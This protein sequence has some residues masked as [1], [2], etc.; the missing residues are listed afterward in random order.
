[1]Q[2]H[3]SLRPTLSGEIPPKAKN[4][5]SSQW[6]GLNADLAH[7]SS[8]VAIAQGQPLKALY[9]SR[10]AVKLMHREWTNLRIP[11]RE[12]RTN[13][14]LMPAKTKADDLVKSMSYLTIHDSAPPPY[15][16]TR[17]QIRTRRK[18]WCIVPRLFESLQQLSNLYAHVG[19][20][21]EAHYY[22]E[23]TQKVVSNVSSVSYQGRFHAQVGQYMSRSNDGDAA[24]IH[25]EKAELAFQSYQLDRSYVDYQ[26]FLAEK[27]TL[28]VEFD[29]AESAFSSADST[30]DHIMD[31]LL[32]YGKSESSEISAI[33]TRM[34][35]VTTTDSYTHPRI[36]R[37][38]SKGK[39]SGP[40]NSCTKGPDKAPSTTMTLLRD[41]RAHV[42]RQR[43][44]TSLRAGAL[45]KA[46]ELL[47]AATGTIADPN[48]RI[49][50]MLLEGQLCLHRGLEAMASDLNFCVLPESSISCPSLKLPH[51]HNAEMTQQ[52]LEKKETVRRTKK[53]L[54]RTVMKATKA[55]VSSIQS[56]FFDNL[57]QAQESLSKIC[58]IATK[59]ASTTNIHTLVDVLSRTRMML[60]SFNSSALKASTQPVGIV[61]VKGKVLVEILLRISAANH[62]CE[63]IGRTLASVR[64][65]VTLQIE[66]QLS[67][68]FGS[69]DWPTFRDQKN[70]CSDNELDFSSDYSNFRTEYIDIIPIDWTVVSLSL[71]ESNH[72][73]SLSRLCSGHNPFVISIP[74]NRHNSRDPDEETF[75]FDEG[76]AELQDIIKLANYSTHNTPATS[77]K[78]AKTE[79]WEARAALDARLKDFLVN[80]ESIWFGGFRGIFSPDV[81]DKDLLLRF[82]QTLHNILDRH[83]PSR[84]KQTKSDKAGRFTLDVQLTELFVRLGKPD[85]ADMDDEL[86]DLL[87]FV[88]DVLQFHGEHNAYDEIDF[89]SIMV[90]TLDALRQYHAAAE[91]TARTSDSQH[92][93]LVLDK[94]LHAFPWESL[95]CMKSHSTSR[96]PSLEFLRH[97][98]LQQQAQSCSPE[99]RFLVNP[100][101]GAYVL[102]PSGDLTTTQSKFEESLAALADW[103]SIVKRE[104]TEEELKTALQDKDLFLYF[105]HGSGGQYI[106]PRTIKRLEKCAVALLMGCSSGTM[107]EAGQYESYGTPLNYMHAGCPAVLATLWDVT[108]KDIDRF[109]QSVLEKWGLFE[110]PQPVEDV[111]RGA[112]PVKKNRGSPVKRC[113]KR[114][115][116]KEVVERRE[117]EKIGLDQAVAQSRDECIMKYLNGAAPVIYGIPVFL[118]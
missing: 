53:P 79:W 58:M 27:Y 13:G 54:M 56:G 99:A 98:I 105:G 114:G 85:A 78:G 107:T 18:M 96:V 51:D 5:E 61:Y 77:R 88:V 68:P 70:P 81:H 47:E 64:E 44:L 101:S 20:L 12:E 57:Q 116:G 50:Q 36:N 108:D 11:Q 76:K 72:E 40:V 115:N 110:T 30:L 65:R 82:Q 2:V 35:G 89:D 66:Q 43:A 26:L 62:I 15:S 3:K 32:S 49:L 118:S 17:Y 37:G 8:T 93:I 14:V 22:M 23:Q 38:T 24:A 80:V 83:L 33:D 19:L 113:A 100:S 29:S 59:T 9:F 92:I 42:L 4:G 95:P 16:E 46:E 67:S 60:S 21:A 41:E 111:G 1:M 106:R 6:A 74:L 39:A 71:S 87:Y 48:Q 28:D 109:S 10:L 34:A 73:I 94:A 86:T 63:E 31:E 84:Q 55:Q 25:F 7:L 97:R 102:N 69:L 112:S 117:R 91:D 104:P 90:E 75:G 45:D 103:T 52:S